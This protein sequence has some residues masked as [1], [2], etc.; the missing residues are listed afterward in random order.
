MDMFCQ[1]NDKTQILKRMLVYRP[2]TVVNEVTRQQNG[3]REDSHIMVRILIQRS[4]PLSVNYKH[5]YWLPVG[6]SPGNGLLPNPESLC[7]RVDGGAYPEAVGSVEDHPVEEVA[8]S[9]SVHAS[10]GHNSEG[11]FEGLEEFQ[12]FFLNFELWTM[13]EIWCEMGGMGM[14]QH[15]LLTLSL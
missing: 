12:G 1:I 6:S 5:I 7:A 14:K 15:L 4:Q 2:H 13:L 8:F 10:D 11:A 9:C 3:Q